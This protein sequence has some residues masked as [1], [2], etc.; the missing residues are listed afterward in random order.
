MERLLNDGWSFVKLPCDAPLDEAARWEPVDL[1]H[2][3]LIGQAEDLYESC[4]GWYR[5]VLTVPEAAREQVW[6][7]R[8]D[9]VYMDC[10]VLLN[11]ETVVTHRCGY[12]AFDADLTGRL[13][14]GDNTLTVRIRHRSPNSRWYSGAGIYRDVT[15]HVLPPRHIPLDGVYVTAEGQGDL[16]RMSVRTELVGPEKGESLTHRLLDGQGACVAEAVLPA[17]GSAATA[18]LTVASP[19]LWSCGEPNRYTLETTLGDQRIRQTVGFRRIELT[20]DRGL[21]LNGQPLKLHGVCLHHDLGALGAAFHL[22]AARRQ[23]TTM[24]AMGVNAL[25]TAHNPPAR[26]VLDLCDELGILVVDEAFDMWER[27][28][29]PFDYARFFPEHAAE[30]VASWVR[31]DRNHP[32]LAMWSIGN[33]IV[34][35]HLS[36]R[37]EELTRWLAEETRRHDPGRNGHVTIGSNYMPWEGAQRCAE[38]IEA[39]GYNYGEKYYDKHHSEH[40]DWVIY[41]SETASILS[42]RGVYR[43]PSRAGI[44]SDED[45]QCSS[46]GNSLTSWGTKDLRRM[47]ADD[48]RTPWSLG[49]FLW[50]G[51]DYIGEPTPYHTR[52]CYFGMADTACFP[53]DFFYLFKALWTEEPVAHIGVHWDWNPGQL[54]DVP[55]MTNGAEAELLLNGRSLGRKAVDR[56]DPERCWP[57]W[58][59]AFEPGELTLRAYDARGN[60]IAVDTRRTPGDSAAIVLTAEDSALYSGGD[61]MTFVTI[62]MADAKGLPVD[63]AVDRVQVRVSGAGRLLGLDNGDST[64]REGYQTTTRRLFSGKL[65]AIIGAAEEPGTARIVVSSPGKADAALDIPVLPAAKTPGLSAAFRCPEAP[66]PAERPVRKLEL[67]PEGSTR[68][69]PDR[70]EV[71]FALRRWPADADPQPVRYRVTTEAGIDTACAEIVSE[72]P[73][74]V[75]VRAL[76]D[77]TVYLRATCDNGYDHP[78]VISQQEVFIS[79]LGA[80]NLDPYG[81]VAGGLHDLSGGEL[82]AGNEQ[83]VSFARDGWSMAGFSRVDFGP[84]GS[85]E[86]TL[87]IFALDDKE[88]VMQLW[89][90]DP[91]QGGERLADLRYQK[92]SRWNVYQPETYRL[93][94]RLT[95]LQ[96]LCFA[97]EAKVHLKGFSFTRQSRAWLP[98]RALGADAVYGDSFR[99]AEEGILGIGNNVTLIFGGMDFG[100]ANRARLV[101]DGATGLHEQPVT[102]RCRDAEGQ[103]L[104]ALAPFR[105]GER[106]EQAFEVDVLPGMCEVSFVFLPGSSFDF[107]GFRFERL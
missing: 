53:K 22:K 50:S 64:D 24:K 5:R 82:G 6:L 77:G 99:R 57:Q 15:L 51:I 45:L 31:R 67:I 20:P 17:A 19:R 81:F 27:P 43:F 11:G 33:E 40:P 1:P 86:V 74:R 41:G 97:M 84:V 28:K 63:N 90:G 14:P 37:G 39:V 38:L 58:Q 92:P 80:P 48:L 13:R 101:I 55:V 35:T 46:L 44:L 73:D 94:R 3:F 93:P 68:L 52:S 75:T 106:S 49:Q 18:L 10:D 88:Y 98:Q 7:L 47:I 42:S 34:D 107:F 32:C 105:G 104:T 56:L 72:G 23:L 25:R 59:A 83:G 8:F 21:L 12:T 54:I 96:T 103:E 95:G 16:W 2:D 78:R 79:G 91:R 65:L 29:N 70:R 26:Q 66:M 9:G 61:D 76:G 87:P 85:D 4:D 89:L 30:D 62:G 60:L 102:I 100:E 36:E 71:T 69:T